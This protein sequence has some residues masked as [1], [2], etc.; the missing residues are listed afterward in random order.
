MKKRNKGLVHLTVV[1]DKQPAHYFSC[2]KTVAK[3]SLSLY[4]VVNLVLVSSAIIKLMDVLS[5]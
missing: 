4:T 2:L 1:F 3:E 5:V